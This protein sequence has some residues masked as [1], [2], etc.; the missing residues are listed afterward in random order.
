MELIQWIGIFLASVA[1]VTVLFIAITVML[2]IV[3]VKAISESTG[4]DV[5]LTINRDGISC[6]ITNNKNK[7]CN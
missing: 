3:L 1:L 7:K 2:S 4:E 5:H 6:E